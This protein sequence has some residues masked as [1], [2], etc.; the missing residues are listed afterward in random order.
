VQ[1]A[2]FGPTDVAHVELGIPSGIRLEQNYPNPF[3]PTTT[4][5]YTVGAV[6]APSGVEGPVVS[7]VKLAIY[8]LLGREVAVLVNDRRAPGIYEVS[9]DGSA[10]PSG[11]Y[12]YRLSAGSFVQS[13]HMIL[14]K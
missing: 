12:L 3:N 8:D 13:R 14:L 11:V 10:L 7:N 2:R 6:V 4:I 1:V 5:G 9:F